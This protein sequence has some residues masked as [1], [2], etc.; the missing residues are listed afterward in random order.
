MRGNY[1]L[2]FL[3]TSTPRQSLS[4][5]HTQLPKCELT[6]AIRCSLHRTKRHRPECNFESSDP[7]R[8]PGLRNRPESRIDT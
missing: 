5:P 6:G 8:S 2:H 3:L 1:G 4:N 7:T